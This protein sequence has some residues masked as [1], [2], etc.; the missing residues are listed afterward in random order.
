MRRLLVVAFALLLA[1]GVGAGLVYYFTTSTAA[2]V[3][4]GKVTCSANLFPPCSVKVEGERRQLC[5]DHP[6]ADRARITVVYQERTFP[7]S[8]EH[9]TDVDTKVRDC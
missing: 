2:T 7:S 6:D 5:A 1:C 3:P 9:V 8:E 4:E